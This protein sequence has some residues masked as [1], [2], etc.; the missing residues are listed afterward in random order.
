MFCGSSVN[1]TMPW[2]PIRPAA[3]WRRFYRTGIF[4]SVLLAGC[5]SWHQ[6]MP[7]PLELTQAGV[8]ARLRIPA[9]ASVNLA[10][11]V[12]GSGQR[13]HPSQ[14]LP[15]NTSVEPEPAAFS[16]ADAIAFAQQHSPRLRS[17]R[18]ALERARG[19]EQGAFVPFLP[20]VDRRFHSAATRGNQGLGTTGR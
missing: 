16:L 12:I 20:E 14:A 6:P 17:A 13:S 18:A 19:Q 4:V 15:L 2:R 11:T 5:S 7:I 9:E 8:Q 1:L 3:G 10:G